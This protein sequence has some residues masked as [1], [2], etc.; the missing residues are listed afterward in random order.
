[1][2]TKKKTLAVLFGGHSSEYEALQSAAAVLE[3]R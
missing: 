1:M 3:A 2:N